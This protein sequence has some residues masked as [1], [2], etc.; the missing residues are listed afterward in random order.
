M[1]VENW[2]I[3]DVDGILDAHLPVKCRAEILIGSHCETA[4]Y[5]YRARKSDSNERLIVRAKDFCKNLNSHYC[6]TYNRGLIVESVWRDGKL[7]YSD[8]SLAV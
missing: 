1:R 3:S 2:P 4:T 5:R 6:S 7:I 8:T